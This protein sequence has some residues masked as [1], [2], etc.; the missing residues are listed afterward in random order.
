MGPLAGIK[1]VEIAGLGPAPMCAMLFADLGATVIRI[2]RKA[3]IDL[4]LKRP[5]KYDL[6]LR[7]RPA[8]AVDLKTREGVELVL[9]LVQKSDVLIE[10]FRPGVMERL[11]LGPDICL[12]RNA[13]LVYGRVTG[14]GQDGPL[15]PAAG[16]DI[17]YIAITG[18]LHAIGRRG[19]APVP[20]LALL[21]DFAGGAM[22]L[23]F[24]VVCAL[25]EAQRS[26]RGQVVDAAISDGT[27]ARRSGKVAAHAIASRSF[28][29]VGSV[30]GTSG[31]RRFSSHN[32][33]SFIT[34]LHGAGEDSIK[35]AS[36]SGRILE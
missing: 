2:E 13:R 14:W 32:P 28:F 29:C 30:T 34:N 16:H 6:L 1:M 10:G 36:I 18:A 26:G 11:G 24:G 3:P 21:G 33:I 15:S 7:S 12:G 17:N 27:S 22:F 20:P 9:S 8:I 4:G 23:A 35:F 25:L 5:R 19:E 31:S